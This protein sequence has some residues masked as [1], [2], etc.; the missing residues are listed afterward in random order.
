MSSLNVVLKAQEKKKK[1]NK[2][3]AKSRAQLR[4][5]KLNDNFTFRYFKP[6]Q[7]RFGKYDMAYVRYAN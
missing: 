6:F 5:K 7:A 1:I 2:P 3:P 4:E